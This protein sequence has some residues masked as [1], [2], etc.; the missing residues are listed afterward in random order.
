MIAR[1]TD[2]S[3]AEYLNRRIAVNGATIEMDRAE[4]AKLCAMA[5]ERPETCAMIRLGTCSMCWPAEWG[6]S[7]AS[8]CDR[9]S[10]WDRQFVW[11]AHMEHPALT[12]IRIDGVGAL[13]R[14]WWPTPLEALA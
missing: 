2:E 7:P 6:E 14:V 9:H 11:L 13:R 10:G 12:E 1:I 5:G 4:L 8:W 3:L